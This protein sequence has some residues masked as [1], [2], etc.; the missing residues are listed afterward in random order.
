MSERKNIIVLLFGDIF[1]D[2]RVKRIIDIAQEIGDVT[3]VDVS[4][5]SST[6]EKSYAPNRLRH[7]RIPL[8]KNWGVLRQHLFFWYSAIRYALKAQ[9]SLILAEDFFTTFPGWLVSIFTKKPLVYDAHELIIPTPGSRMSPRDYF[10]YFL[11]RFVVPRASAIFSASKERSEL[12]MAHYKLPHE[13]SYMLNIPTPVTV[14]ELDIIKVK[15]VHP[16]LIKTREDERII[17]YQGSLTAARGIGRFLEAL[18]YLPDNIRF[19]MVGGGPDR[20]TL[21]EKVQEHVKSGRVKFVGLVPQEDLAAIAECA[22]IGI[23]CYPSTGL[24]NIYC[25]STK[26]FEYA[27]AGIPVLSTDNPPLRDAIGRY[28]NGLLVSKNSKA[29]EIARQITELLTSY[30]LYATGHRSFLKENPHR[31]EHARILALLSSVLEG[32]QNEP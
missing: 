1:Y 13:P 16:E 25:S 11:E 22:D 2:G 26:L 32:G 17:L 14:S 15:Q 24:N 8:K 5:D 29:D 6:N 27:Y 30:S 7:I 4:W 3:L 9:P 23:I 19:I 28:G 20:Q 12:M 21:E 31:T 10:W 18:E